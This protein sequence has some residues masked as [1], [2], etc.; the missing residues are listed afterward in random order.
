MCVLNTS[1]T[2]AYLFDIISVRHS[3]S[4]FIIVLKKS[5]SNKYTESFAFPSHTFTFYGRPICW[6]Y[7]A[8]IL[9]KKYFALNICLMY[10]VYP[11]CKVSDRIWN[12][13]KQYFKWNIVLLNTHLLNLFYLNRGEIGNYKPHECIFP[14]SISPVSNVHVFTCI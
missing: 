1:L 10:T 5:C 12:F 8:V 4:N 13:F 9:K 14:R 2:F 6:S 3:N 11:L 7:P